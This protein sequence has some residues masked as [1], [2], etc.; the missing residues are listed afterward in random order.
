[1]V[2]SNTLVEVLRSSITIAKMTLYSTVK[3]KGEGP[4]TH[5][6]SV[7]DSNNCQRYFNTLYQK[8]TYVRTLDPFSNHYG[9]H[10]IL[11]YIY[12]LS[13][14][15]NDSYSIHLNVCYPEKLITYG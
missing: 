15:K 7:T 11:M 8:G 10:V 1:M 12:K 2:T 6:L 3:T 9:N 4:G 14:Y 5:P 13:Y